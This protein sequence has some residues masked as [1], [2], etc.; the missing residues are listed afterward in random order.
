MLKY[1]SL[2]FFII[3]SVSFLI[4]GLSQSLKFNASASGNNSTAYDKDRVKIFIDNSDKAIDVSNDFTIEFWIKALPGDNDAGSCDPSSWYFG[5]IV[6]DRDIF[7]SGDFGDFG[8]VICN[9][10]IVFGVERLSNGSKGVIGN[11]IID[12]GFWHHIA[13]TRQASNG[14]MRLYVDGIQDAFLNTSDASGDISYN[15]GRY[16]GY[17]NSDPYLVLGAEKHDYQDSKYFKG[18]LDELRISN[19]LRYSNGF[20]RP[21][22][23]FINDNYTVGL[24]HFDENGGNTLFDFS[25]GSGSPSNGEIKYY[26]S[27]PYPQWFTDDTPFLK[28]TNLNDAGPGSLRQKIADAPVGSTVYF[29]SALS[30]MTISLTSGPISISKKLII[31]VDSDPEITINTNG[32]GPCFNILAGASVDFYNISIGSGSG[33]SGSAIV[34]NGTILLQNI[35]ILQQYDQNNTSVINNG[36]LIINGTSAIKKP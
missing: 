21:A 16:T 18:W 28:V 27:N 24:Y 15:H 30:G 8:I 20:T 25:T 3:F 1:L 7:G 17:P 31:T 35:N 34:N 29:D 14:Q 22:L 2:F 4:K 33:N 36:T 26:G 32:P 9:R 5:N 6:V 10:R 19:I 12:D 13:V 23:P 11:T